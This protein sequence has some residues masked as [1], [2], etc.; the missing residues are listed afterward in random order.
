[1]KPFLLLLLG[2]FWSEIAAAQYPSI[3]Y[4]FAE[5]GIANSVNN[6]KSPI[7]KGNSLVL[8][9]S[10]KNQT[11]ANIGRHF[12]S[13][14]GHFVEI[15]FHSRFV[16]D[17]LVDSA[18]LTGIRLGTGKKRMRGFIEVDYGGQNGNFSSYTIQDEAAGYFYGAGFRYRLTTRMSAQASFLRNHFSQFFQVQPPYKHPVRTLLATSLYWN[19]NI[20]SDKPAKAPKVKKL[21]PRRQNR[22]LYSPSNT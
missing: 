14:E 16:G 4:W 13:T 19:L 11:Y 3:N 8:L 20:K 18:V 5:L 21:S 10:P 1:M 22:C 17:N 12:E 2:F 15:F 7:K 6:S 9:W